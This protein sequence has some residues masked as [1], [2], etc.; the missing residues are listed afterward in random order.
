METE[1]AVEVDTIAGR[2]ILWCDL[3]VWRLR[4]VPPPTSSGAPRF[5]VQNLVDLFSVI[6]NFWDALGL[7]LCKK[8]LTQKPLN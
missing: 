8:R 1:I 5:M 4:P 7:E 2:Y 3:D 6:E